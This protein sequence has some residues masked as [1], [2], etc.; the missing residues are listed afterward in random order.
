MPQ[1]ASMTIPPGGSSPG[2][3]P[4]RRQSNEPRFPATRPW[5]S[6][7][8][9]PCRSSRRSDR[10]HL[11]FIYGPPGVGKLTVATELARLTGF[12]VFHNHLSVNLVDSLFERLT[13]P[14]N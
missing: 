4:K 9:R 14:F 8:S 3:Y 11:V 12:K 2:A 6:G 10:M 5:P 1:C 7:F 13:P